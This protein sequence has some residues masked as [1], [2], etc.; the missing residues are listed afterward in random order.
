MTYDAWLEKPYQD[1]QRNAD[2]PREAEEWLDHE[3]FYQGERA[4]VESWETWE[5]ADED[6]RYGGFD[7]VIRIGGEK[8]EF[9]L[10]SGGRTE[11]LS[12]NQ[13]EEALADQ[14]WHRPEE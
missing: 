12:P 10:W 5:D 6:G 13:L 1:S 2:P 7:F 9:N 14:A 8:G 3:F 4:V 11:N